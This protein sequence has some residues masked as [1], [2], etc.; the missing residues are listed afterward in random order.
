MKYLKKN[1]FKVIEKNYLCKSG[2]I[3]IIAS[4]ENCL[5]FIEVKASDEYD[6]IE[7]LRAAKKKRLIKSIE[8][9]LLKHP[10][11]QDMDLALHLLTVANGKCELVEDILA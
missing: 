5:Y 7:M 9:Y 8:L 2:E 11:Y 4:K 6:T 10:Q 3:D 1:G